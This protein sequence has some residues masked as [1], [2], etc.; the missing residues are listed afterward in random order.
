[1]LPVEPLTWFR[2]PGAVVLCRALAGLSADAGDTAKRNVISEQM[3]QEGGEIVADRPGV[4]HGA[5]KPIEFRDDEGVALRV[6]AA[7]AW[8]RPERARLVPVSP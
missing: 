1:M 5:S 3:D 2:R 4:G 6:T 8:S 7:S